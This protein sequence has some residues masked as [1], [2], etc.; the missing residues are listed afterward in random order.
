MDSK[1]WF[2]NYYSNSN[3]IL[4]DIIKNLKYGEVRIVVHEKQPVRIYAGKH[5][6]IDP[7][8]EIAEED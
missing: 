5:Y 1:T 8:E 2:N 4:L 6:K 7:K 3:K